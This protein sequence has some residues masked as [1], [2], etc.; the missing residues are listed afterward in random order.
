M[1]ESWGW[2]CVAGTGER[3]GVPRP[4]GAGR[5]A[6]AQ[7]PGVLWTSSEPPRASSRCPPADWRAAPGPCSRWRTAAS[8]SAPTASSPTPGGRCAPC[9]W[10]RPWRRRAAWRGGLPGDRPHRH[11]DLLLGPGL[12]GR[13]RAHRPAGGHLRRRAGSAAAAG[14]PGAPHHHRGLLPPGRAPCP[15]CAPTSTCPC[16]AAATRRSDG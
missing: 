3:L 5:L 9:R 14:L 8:T 1:T 12:Q 4:A 2:T 13:H 10:S 11:R 15:T 7:R 6:R 16:R